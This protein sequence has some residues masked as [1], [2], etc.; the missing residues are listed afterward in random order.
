MPKPFVHLH[1]HSQYS[2]LD[3]ANRLDDVLAAGK[4]AGMPAMALTDR[5]PTGSIGAFAAVGSLVEGFADELFDRFYGPA[6]GPDAVA[7][8]DVLASSSFFPAA[9]ADGRPRPVH[10]GSRRSP[11]RRAC[12]R[13]SSR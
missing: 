5:I 11:T 7:D 8:W 6:L 4:D 12:P 2:L 10:A 9:V 1:L 3:G 13:P